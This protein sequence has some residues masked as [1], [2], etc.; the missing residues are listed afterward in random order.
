MKNVIIKN[1]L[2]QFKEKFEIIE[3]EE[4]LIF[5]QFINYCILN[6]HIID[7]EKSFN[8]MDT[9][10]A[11][12]IDG[13]AILVNNKMILN[14]DDLNQLI[15]NKSILSVDFIFVQTK[16]SEHFNDTEVNYFI[17]HVK[18]FIESD[19][20]TIKELEKFWELR[21][22]IYNNSHLFRKGNPNCIMYYANCSPTTELS[23]DLNLTIEDGKK[24]ISNTGLVSDNIEFIPLGVKEIQKLYRKID[25]DLEAQFNFP[26]NVTFSYDDEKITSAYFGIVEIKEYVKLLLDSE[27]KGIKNVFE[28]NIRDYL[29]TEYNEVNKNMKDRLLGDESQLFGILNN[30]VTIIA[31]DIKPVGEKFNLTNYQVV[32]GCQTSN[33]I[34]E[35]MQDLKDKKIYIPL[36][37]IATQDEDTKNEII[38]STNSQTGLKP[39]QLDSLNNFHRMLEDFYYSKNSLI[40]DDNFRIKLYYE[41]RLNQYRNEDIPQTRII[42]ISKQI[43][44]VASMFLDNP[45]GVSGHYGTVIKKVKDDIFKPND[46]PEVY[47]VSALLLYHVELFFKK[48]KEYKSVSRM[49]WHILMVIKHLYSKKDFSNKLDSKEIL[50]VCKSIEKELIKEE[51]ANRLIVNA[52]NI[53]NDMI[54]EKNLDINDRKIFERK[55]TTEKLKQFLLVDTQL[56]CV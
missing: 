7:S 12:A 27:T 33:V 31:D 34:F 43:K 37:L 1:F 28:D 26:K 15:Q 35:N 13:V 8:E 6:N 46:K 36:K 45:H 22:I 20:C 4:S 48:N 51:S 19:K 40:K 54:I 49:K 30:G 3:I 47:Y 5:E 2:N 14:E 52:I 24:N 10:T 41:R 53:I 21:N 56:K 9:G 18:K 29:G 32:N 44:S 55:E 23:E 38:K 17:N 16:S 42:N 25:A 50:K 11:K 39:E